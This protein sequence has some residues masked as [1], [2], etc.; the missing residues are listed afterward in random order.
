[1]CAAVL[2]LPGVEKAGYDLNQ[3]FFSL[4]YDADRVKLADIFAA[5]VNGGRK[6]GQEY[7]PKLREIS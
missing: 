7:W 6:M 5:V 3:D 1:M 4:E 2:A